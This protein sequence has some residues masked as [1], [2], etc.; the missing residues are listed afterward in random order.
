MIKQ[1]R[2]QYPTNEEGFM[3]TDPDWWKQEK[4]QQHLT[5]R[6]SPDCSAAQAAHCG[7]GHLKEGEEQALIFNLLKFLEEYFIIKTSVLF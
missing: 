6:S 4:E 7:W 2:Y 5:L 3:S 1:I